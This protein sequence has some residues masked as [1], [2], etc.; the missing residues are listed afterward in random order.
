MA[1]NDK[2]S[3][4]VNK[5]D[6]MLK[7]HNGVYLE[8]QLYMKLKKKFPNLTR[9]DFNEVLDELLQKDYVM[10]HELIRPK[11]ERTKRSSYADDT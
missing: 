4:I 10:E 3:R 7:Q 6:D 1:E 9:A 11:V 5:A 8:K 2:I